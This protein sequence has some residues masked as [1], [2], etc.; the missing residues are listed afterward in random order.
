M[1]D[2]RA[3]SRLGFSLKK[4]MCDSSTGESGGKCILTLPL[5]DA[6]PFAEEALSCTVHVGADWLKRPDMIPDGGGAGLGRGAASLACARCRLAPTRGMLSAAA[7]RS[8]HKQ[9][10]AGPRPARAAEV[11]RRSGDGIIFGRR[12]PSVGPSRQ[13]RP[14]ASARGTSRRGTGR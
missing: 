12:E 8:A 1:L 13:Q 3:A 6:P 7:R 11:G 2:K 4:I 14:R 9:T 10:R 5:T